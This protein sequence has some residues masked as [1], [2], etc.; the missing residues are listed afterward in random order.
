M[1]IAK[2]GVLILLMCLWALMIAGWELA[3]YNAS[4]SGDLFVNLFLCA[5][6]NAF[7]LVPTGLLIE[8]L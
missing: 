5:M 1:I 3:F 4:T 8:E 2:Y 6:L 7:L